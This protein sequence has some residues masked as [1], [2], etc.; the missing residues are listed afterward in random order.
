[1]YI[2][3]YIVMYSCITYDTASIPS[4]GVSPRLSAALATWLAS[5]TLRQPQELSIGVWAI[6]QA[7][8][9]P[10]TQRNDN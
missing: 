10:P 6:A 1:M 2:Y 4:G 7:T 3:V 5:N 8:A 9:A